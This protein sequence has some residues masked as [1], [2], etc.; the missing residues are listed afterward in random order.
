MFLLTS[1]YGPEA[2]DI[3]SGQ[4][5]CLVNEQQ[6]MNNRL[7]G[8]SNESHHL[9]LFKILIMKFSLRCLESFLYQPRKFS[10]CAGYFPSGQQ[11]NSADAHSAKTI[12]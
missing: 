5:P 4:Q 10:P 6:P 1:K 8:Q 12:R 11:P 7:K 2:G 3:L 9:N